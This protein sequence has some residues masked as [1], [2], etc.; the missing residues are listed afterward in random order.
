MASIDECGF[1]W[2]EAHPSADKEACE[3][4]R[5]DNQ[6]DEEKTLWLQCFLD[7]GPRRHG[8]S[9]CKKQRISYAYGEESANQ[10]SSVIEPRGQNVGEF[11]EYCEHEHGDGCRECK[12][13][14]REQA[15]EVKRNCVEENAQNDFNR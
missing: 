4:K 13:L 1:D 2:E 7:G 5:E 10:R 14:V 3:G 11:E 6:S 8:D 15:E 12:K 9:N